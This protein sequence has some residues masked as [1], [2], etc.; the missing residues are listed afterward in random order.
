MLAPSPHGVK[1]GITPTRLMLPTLATRI[2]GNP[3]IGRFRRNSPIR[4]ILYN[5]H[6]TVAS[7]RKIPFSRLGKRALVL[8]TRISARW[9]PWSFY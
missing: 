6:K 2:P 8:D 1:F 7:Y 4:H 9:A 5:P 3:L